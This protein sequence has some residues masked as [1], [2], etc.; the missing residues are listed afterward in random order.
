MLRTIGITAIGLLTLLPMSA[1]AAPS[2]QLVDP[3]GDTPVAS[4]DI[5]SAELS[6]EGRPGREVL[7]IVATYAGSV[8]DVVP[9]TRGLTFKVGGCTFAAVQY[10]LSAPTPFGESHVGCATGESQERAGTVTANGSTLLFRV[11]LDGKDLRLGARVT[12]LA[13][14]THPGGFISMHTPLTMAGDVA[15]GR[16][17]VI[18]R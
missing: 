9:Y 6:V 10:S 5:L 4:G 18:S 17:W 15:E 8:T 16:D 12:D 7:T 11:R 3:A 13:A 2:P 14:Y 1:G